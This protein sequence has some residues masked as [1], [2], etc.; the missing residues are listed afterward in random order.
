MSQVNKC[1]ICEEIIKEYPIFYR[2]Y[3]F[4]VFSDLTFRRYE[5]CNE[6]KIKFEMFREQTKV[7]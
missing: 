3:E 6:C 4:F 5:L 1:D 2:A 7:K